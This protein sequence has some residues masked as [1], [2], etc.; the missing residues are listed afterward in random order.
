MRGLRT[1]LPLAFALATL[2]TGCKP[3]FSGT[4]SG[5]E[6]VRLQL[7]TTTPG[8]GIADNNISD[9]NLGSD[10]VVSESRDVVSVDYRG[11]HFT[12]KHD[13]PSQASV[14]PF[15]CPLPGHPGVTYKVAS[16]FLSLTADDL[17]WSFMGTAEDNRGGSGAFESTFMGHRNAR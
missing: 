10:V 14:E 9:R 12:A 13:V 3:K 8:G 5:D 6:D 4:Y 16:G 17:S 7:R 2:A 11:C 15:E 1:K